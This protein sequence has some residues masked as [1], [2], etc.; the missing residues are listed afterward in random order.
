M[1]PHDTEELLDSDDLENDVERYIEHDYHS[2]Y[3]SFFDY[4]YDRFKQSG[5]PLFISGTAEPWDQV[6]TPDQFREWSRF[7]LILAILWNL[8]GDDHEWQWRFLMVVFSEGVFTSRDPPGLWI[9]MIVMMHADLTGMIGVGKN[10]N[11]WSERYEIYETWTVGDLYQ[12]LQRPIARNQWCMKLCTEKWQR[13]GN[14]DAV[15]YIPL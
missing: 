14:M 15:M 5:T 6:T 1:T 12:E 7:G 11:Q 2:K 8:R 3:I 10:W 9:S 13:T 4:F